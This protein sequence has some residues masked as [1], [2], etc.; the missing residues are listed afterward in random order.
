M[1]VLDTLNEDQKDSIAQFQLFIYSPPPQSITHIEDLDR[2]IHILAN[3]NWN[4]EASIY[5]HISARKF[6]WHQNIFDNTAEDASASD[7]GPATDRPARPS[8]GSQEHTSGTQ[9]PLSAPT[10]G[11]SPPRRPL[12][13]SAISPLCIR[14]YPTATFYFRGLMLALSY[15]FGFCS[16][17]RPSVP[18]PF[19]RPRRPLTLM[20][21]LS[22][23]FGL[24]WNISWAILSFALQLLTRQPITGTARPGATQAARQDP[25]SVA[26]RFLLDFETHYGNVHPNFHQ[27]GYSQALEIAKRDLKFL[28]VVLQS[29]EHDET[30]AFCRLLYAYQDDS[31]SISFYLVCFRPSSD[32]LSSPTLNSYLRDNDILVWAGNVRETEAFQVSTTLQSTT[33]PFLAIIG[34]Q[35]PAAGS[36]GSPKMSV[37]DRL[38]GP[39]TADAVVRRLTNALQHY[40]PPLE[41][42][43]RERQEREHDRSLREQQDLAYRESLRIDQEKVNDHVYDFDH[44]YV[45]ITFPIHSPQERKAREAREAAVRAEET[46]RKAQEELQRLVENRQLYRRYLLSTIPAEPSANEEDGVARLSFRMLDGERV[47]RRFKGDENVETIYR[48]V[49]SYSLTK[50]TSTP[51]TTPP[52]GY[53]HRYEFVLV[54]PFPRT[55]HRPDATQLIRDER[56]LW[57]SANL[58]VEGVEEEEGLAA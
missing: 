48:F 7:S 40:G 10:T 41:R 32:T 26:A 37:V 49:E 23:P 9:R 46:A 17:S 16:I 5:R 1:D 44:V 8:A 14:N 22:W 2:A 43:R 54:S 6:T 25:A 36:G 34:L 18:P 11:P 15:N 4:L 58:I 38:E 19:F 50:D 39:T 29:D 21:I 27:G 30:E 51:V 20:S 35:Y 3:H 33:F 52:A 28:V 12:S 31:R 57:P 42:V 53:E 47:V 56:G 55:T 24:A 13:L 45:V